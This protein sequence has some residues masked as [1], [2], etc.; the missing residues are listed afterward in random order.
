MSIENQAE[1]YRRNVCDYDAS[2]VSV[3]AHIAEG[4]AQFSEFLRTIFADWRAYE[5]STVK[6]ERT[7][8][9]IMTD[10]LENYHNLTYT[11]DTLYAISAVGILMSEGESKYLSVN[12]RLFKGEYKQ[13]ATL[14]LVMLEKYGFHFACFKGEKTAEFNRCDS[15]NVGY[16]NGAELIEAV[17][18]LV[19]QL[20]SLERNKSMAP[21]T[22]F[23]LA[24]YHFALTGEINQN[25]TQSSVVNTVGPLGEM[26]KKLASAI[27]DEC[28]LVADSSFNPYVFPDRT[29][30]FKQ[31]KR[32]VCKFG[33]SVDR[34]SVRLPLSF[35]SAKA[36]VLRRKTLPASVN[37]NID[38]FHCINC[39]KCKDE[40]NIEIVEGVPLCKLSY[41]NFMVEDS[42]CLRFD[43]TSMD[44]VDVI[45]DVIRESV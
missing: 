3:T 28:G 27:G 29:I 31:G 34:L 44:E 5:T 11:L 43:V 19:T 12:K 22:A 9:G 2:I 4:F 18:F 16:E 13:S 36:L 21:K 17:S 33:I 38:W 40:A 25:P 32:S 41:K 26:W 24:D 14:P 15:F 39:G 10:D 20:R 6:S 37:Q 42:T 1:F 23:M 7:K 30:T 8:I 45:C 35:E